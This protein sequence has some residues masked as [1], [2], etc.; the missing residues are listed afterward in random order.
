VGFC[1][2][3]RYLR[4]GPAKVACR[5]HRSTRISMEKNEGVASLN[6]DPLTHFLQRR[7]NPHPLIW[8]DRLATQAGFEESSNL[9]VDY[10]TRDC[11]REPLLLF[12]GEY[13]LSKNRDVARAGI[14]P[15]LY[16]LSVGAKST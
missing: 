6:D 7:G 8:M 5:V 11:C 15:L 12:H 14:N 2:F 13:Y 9:L 3:L 1:H 16:Y 4:N 10:L